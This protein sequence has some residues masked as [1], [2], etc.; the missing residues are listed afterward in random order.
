MDWQ[1]LTRVYR[2]ALQA[3][4]HRLLGLPNNP[5]PDRPIGSYLSPSHGLI[6]ETGQIS[7]R[8]AINPSN[9]RE[10]QSKAR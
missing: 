5:Y 1:T 4:I 8:H 9:V 7:R 3:K 6:D 10:W 2:A